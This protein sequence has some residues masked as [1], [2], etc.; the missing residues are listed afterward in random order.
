LDASRAVEQNPDLP[1]DVIR[2][3]GHLSC[4]VVRDDSVIREP[5]PGEALERFDLAGFE[6]RGVAVD[7]DGVAPAAWVRGPWGID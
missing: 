7:L 4:E 3:G 1:A 6:A 5:A 2:E